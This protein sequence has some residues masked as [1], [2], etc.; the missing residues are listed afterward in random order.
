MSFDQGKKDEIKDE[1]R[2]HKPV[3]INYLYTDA[4]YKKNEDPQWSESGVSK[5]SLLFDG[6]S[7]YIEYKSN[8]MKAQGKEWSVNVWIA[9]RAFEWDDPNAAHEGKEN[10]TA[11]VSQYNKEKKQ[12]VLL[13]YERFGKLCF[14]VG[15][16]TKWYTIWADGSNI[17]KYEWNQVTVV[18]DGKKGKIT[19]YLDGKVVALENIPKGS[20]IKAAQNE[21]FLIGKNSHAE[22]I[23]AGTYNMFSGL[24]DELKIYSKAI[25]PKKVNRDK[26]PKIAYQDISLQNILQDDDFKTQYHG[27]P[28][29]FWMNEPHAP[30]YYNG[31]YHL[32]YQENMIG[33]YWRN[34]CWGHLVSKDMVNWTPIKEAITPTENSVVPDGVW[35]GG[36]TTDANG[37]PVLFFTAGN[38]SYATEGLISNQN[39]GVAYPKNLKD[40]NLTD[41]VLGDQLAIKQKADEGK[42]GEFRDPSIIKVGNIWCMFICSG[43]TDGNGGTALLYET[44]KLEVKKNGKIDMDWKY[45]GPIYEMNHPSGK[46]GTSWELPVLIPLTNKAGT[47]TKYLFMI[48]PAP[49]ATSD[50]NIYY[51]IGN[52][53]VKTGKFTP[54]A[55]FL[56]APRLMDY[57]TNV[58]TGPS[59]FT[60]PV[61]KNVYMFS[62]MQDQRNG[63]EE[64]A[65]GW[66]HCVGLTR[67]LWLNDDGTDLKMS[68]IKNLHSLENKVLIDKQNITV[69]KANELLKKVDEDLVHV[70]VTFK[71]EDA[72]EFGID[73]KSNEK[74]TNTEFEYDVEDELIEGSTTAPGKMASSG[75]CS[76][77][78]QLDDGEMTMDIYVDRSLVEAFQ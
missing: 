78:L 47:I 11:I 61:S 21:D 19:L 69:T 31:M 52:F 53:D 6:N 33:T 17:K 58:F 46:Y 42:S 49:A 66:A 65:A 16:G 48:S 35:S 10:L 57:G 5:G 32:F 51:F 34:I 73:V 7:T 29:Q 77:D 40:K 45:M 13:G 1:T 18:F 70:K 67:Q 2:K 55:D 22:S 68:P 23:A 63:T 26:I 28:Y 39:I 74:N 25:T 20:S 9:P 54:D 36:A 41:W 71:A 38:D 30:I 60:D 56:D 44:N 76:G 59:A 4:F 15:T 8:D 43:S 12:G 24:M 3:D 72:N 37:V 64:G 75:S 27:G 50:N 14:E 62:I